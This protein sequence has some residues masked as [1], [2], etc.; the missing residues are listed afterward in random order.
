MALH[1]AVWDAGYHGRGVALLV[2]YHA[3]GFTLQQFARI[4]QLVFHRLAS[5]T[6]STY[7]GA[8]QHEGQRT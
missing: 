4:G 6:D 7:A 5:A 1:T 8:Y 2:V 3:D